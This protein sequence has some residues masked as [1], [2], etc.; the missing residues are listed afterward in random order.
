MIEHGTR[1]YLLATNDTLKELFRAGKLRVASEL[2]AY[3]PFL[4]ASLRRI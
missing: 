4:L 3:L 1:E 2:E